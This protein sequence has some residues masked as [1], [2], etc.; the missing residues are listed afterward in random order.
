[1]S[2]VLQFLESLG[3]DGHPAH[4]VGREFEAMVSSLDI[5]EA[6]RQALVL[7]HIADLPVHAIAL[8]VGVAEGTIKARLSRG[9]TALAALLTDQPTDLEGGVSHA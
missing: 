4:L 2:Q 1:M 3:R 5:D 6:Q 7:H 8:E 9:R